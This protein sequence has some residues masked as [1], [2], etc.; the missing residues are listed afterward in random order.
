MQPSQQMQ[1]RAFGKTQHHFM[2]KIQKN[3]GKIG[4]SLSVTK[5]MYNKPTANIILSGKM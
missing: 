3:I 1:I 4:P 2:T 5:D